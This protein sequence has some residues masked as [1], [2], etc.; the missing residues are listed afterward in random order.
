MTNV[1]LQARRLADTLRIM[2][3][4]L[5]ML[6]VA[7]AIL[8]GCA[9]PYELAMNPAKAPVVDDSASVTGVPKYKR[10]MLVPPA[11]RP[12]TDIDTDLATIE[13]EL[14]RNGVTLL[15]G[16]ARTENDGPVTA[17]GRILA[18]AK[19]ANADAILEIIRFGP[20]HATERALGARFFVPEGM[21]TVR[22][23]GDEMQRMILIKSGNRPIV[24][25]DEASYAK[26]AGD[27]RALSRL[28]EDEVMEFTG[29]LVEVKSREIMTSLHYY[30]PGVRCGRP[31]FEI[32]DGKG[33]TS[34]QAYEWA[35]DDAKH[36]RRALARKAIIKSLANRIGGPR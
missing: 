17:D 34:V 9:T 26:L 18:E 36:L 29:R 11:G 22:E 25:T 5:P 13:R 30:A 15:I 10:I 7:A 20:A 6:V 21:G 24:E 23:I 2:K 31:Y 33:K 28:Y 12:G 16:G 32:M 8:A 19:A 3:T 4:I 1:A 14:I 27:Q 35:D